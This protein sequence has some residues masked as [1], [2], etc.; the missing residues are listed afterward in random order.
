MDNLTEKRFGGIDYD[1]RPT[2]YWEQESDPLTAILR[3]VKGRN[4]RQMIRDYWDEGRLEELDDSLLEGELDGDVRHKLG[5]IHPSFMGG[6]YL[7]PMQ[8]QEIEIARIELKSVM[9]DV[10]SIRASL[11][12]DWKI[13]YRVVDEHEAEFSISPEESDS[14]VSLGELIGLIDG[15]N[16]GDGGGLALVYNRYNF[17]IG[18]MP[19]EGLRHFTTVSSDIYP[20]LFKHYDALHEEWVQAEGGG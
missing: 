5:R 4:R 3:N 2:S 20:D 11:G 6:E 7:P 1:F 10:T 17:G 18:A 14:P 13:R 8:P 19:A 9:A 15:V 12:D 16:G